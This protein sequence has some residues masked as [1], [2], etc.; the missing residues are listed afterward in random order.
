MNQINRER[1][2]FVY[3]IQRIANHSI[4]TG[5]FGLIKGR[6]GLSDQVYARIIRHRERKWLYQTNDALIWNALGFELRGGALRRPTDIARHIL[7]N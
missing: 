3:Q 5:I 7:I 4:A 1:V 6:I 2:Y